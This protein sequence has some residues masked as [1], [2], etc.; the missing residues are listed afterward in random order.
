M[1]KISGNLKNI[2]Y[3]G[4]IEIDR[5]EALDLFYYLSDSNKLE[6]QKEE[7]ISSKY[8]EQIDQI[9]SV[10]N[11]YRE[12][13]IFNKIFK[14]ITQRYKLI[15]KALKEIDNVNK[16]YNLEQN[17]KIIIKYV[18]EDK[19]KGTIKT[20]CQYHDSINKIVLLGDSTIDNKVWVNYNEKETFCGLLSQKLA[21][22][23]IVKNFANDGFTT[24]DMLNGNYK[25]KVFSI[26]KSGYPHEMF[27]PLIASKDH[28]KYANFVIVSVLGN[29]YREFLSNL[30]NVNNR[31]EVKEKFFSLRQNAIKNYLD[32]IK[33]IRAQ[34]VEAKIILETQYYPS[35]LDQPYGIYGALKLLQNLFPGEKLFSGQSKNFISDLMEDLYTTIFNNEIIKNDENIF[36]LDN[37]TVLNPHNNNN[38]VSQIE[39][40]VDGGDLIAGCLSQ[41]ICKFDKLEE[42]DKT[43]RVFVMKDGGLIQKEI[44]GWKPKQFSSWDKVNMN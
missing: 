29:D 6:Q 39:P 7:D 15:L 13:L 30:S 8:K 27:E 12:H 36:I 14:R 11:D 31:L 35:S 1:N 28:I 24:S 2:N 22:R 4:K 17:N 16:I 40:S 3:T 21:G 23:A 18:I 26:G 43:S 19:S 5:N 9:N 37:T 41:I 33:K 10:K 38:Y 32:I 44:E 42:L 20:A 34:N 25:D